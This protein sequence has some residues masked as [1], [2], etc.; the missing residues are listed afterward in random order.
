MIKSRVF[1]S[2]FLGQSCW[3]AQNG[4]EIVPVHEWADAIHIALLMWQ[5]SKGRFSGG[6]CPLQ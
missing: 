5:E 4:K 6:F 2:L 1:K 3:I